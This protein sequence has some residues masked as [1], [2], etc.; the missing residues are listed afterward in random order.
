MGKTTSINLVGRDEF[1]VIMEVFARCTDAYMFLFD[2]DKD[3]Y[4]ISEQILDKF[5]LPCNHFF[6]AKE[7]LEKVIYPEA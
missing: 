1:E 5:D 7:V 3:E 2:L 6:N 4:I